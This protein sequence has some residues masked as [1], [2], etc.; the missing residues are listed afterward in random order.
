MKTAPTTL[1]ETL[2]QDLAR[3]I[4]RG[5]LPPGLSLPGENELAQQY[6]VSRT[7]VRNALQVLAAKGLISIQAKKR[8]TVNSRQQWSFLDTDVLAWLAEDSLDPLLIEQLMV[9]RLIFEPNIAALA[10]VNA[11]GH[12]LAA[13]EDAC[14]LMAQGQQQ[15]SRKLFEQGDMAFHLALLGASHNPFLHSLG[16]ALSAAMALSFQQTLE[17]DVRLAQKAVEEHQQLLEAIRFKQVENARQ[18]MRVILLNAARKNNWHKQPEMF[19]H[20]L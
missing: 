16:S 4:I 10:A 1:S 15:A 2:T 19:A 14:K 3:R 13:L 6:E 5:D 17:E 18:C 20:I 8:S 7:S 12:D 11:T 9:T